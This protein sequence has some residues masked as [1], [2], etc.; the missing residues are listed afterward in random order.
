MLQACRIFEAG[1]HLPTIASCIGPGDTEVLKVWLAGFPNSR[2]FCRL[3]DQ[4]TRSAYHNYTHD[5]EAHDEG[6]AAPLEIPVLHTLGSH[7]EFE[8]HDA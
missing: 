3:K 7:R 2:F 5:C 1:S 4:S 6:Y 8:R